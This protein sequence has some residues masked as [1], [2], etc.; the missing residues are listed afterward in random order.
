MGLRHPVMY[1][2]A[3]MSLV[4]SAANELI[5]RKRATNYRALLRKMTYKDKASCNVWRCANE[6]R[7]EVF[8]SLLH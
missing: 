4:M 3:R 8:S 7:Y 5:F 1:G 6:L 2:V